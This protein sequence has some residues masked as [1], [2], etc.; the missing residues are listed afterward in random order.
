[1]KKALFIWYPKCSTCQ[2]AAKWLDENGVDFDARDIV[3]QNPTAA[4]LEQWIDASGL[5]I[6]K[7]FNTSGLKY[8]ALGLAAKVKTADKA[9][10]LSLLSSD[11]M[12]VKRPIIVA[13]GKVLV[14]FKPE[15]WAVIL[16]KY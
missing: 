9:E 6:T 7:F 15:K 5:E 13:N 16:A 14:G 4:E 1:M 2:K 11:G 12:L 3:I 8:R 10:L